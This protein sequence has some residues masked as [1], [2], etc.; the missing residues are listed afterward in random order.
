MRSKINDSELHDAREHAFAFVADVNAGKTVDS[1]KFADALSTFVSRYEEAIT[2][3]C[4]RQFQK[5]SVKEIAP[6][7]LP[8]SYKDWEHKKCDPGFY[9]ANARA[10]VLTAG[11]TV[12]CLMR[13]QT[14]ALELA[15][16]LVWDSD[17]LLLDMEKHGFG[18][19]SHTQKAARMLLIR[20]DHLL[21]TLEHL[22][23]GTKAPGYWAFS[24]S[25]IVAAS[26]RIAIELFLKHCFGLL[27]VVEKDSEKP[28]FLQVQDFFSVIEE[29]QKELPT[30]IEVGLD[31]SLLKRM[32]QWANLYIH[33]AITQYTW[34]PL[35]AAELLQ[36][37]RLWPGESPTSVFF[38]MR[39]SR[40]AYNEGQRKLRKK[41]SDIVCGRPVLEKFISR[42][43][44]IVVD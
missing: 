41:A 28:V 30:E 10:L 27:G 23:Y 12:Q 25:V 37:L 40:R 22:S 6:W 36:Q 14:E 38:G 9:A 44:S 42:P 5:F 20:P 4:S 34:S 2:Y 43:C 13:N 7:V 39:L 29:L 19:R 15:S 11:K 8:L 32:N 3:A 33:A 24:R 35:I 1:S 21:N 18:Q 26:V 16:M 17:L 31:I